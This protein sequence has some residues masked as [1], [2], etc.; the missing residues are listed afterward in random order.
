M[1]EDMFEEKEKSE[2]ARFKLNEELRFKATARR[3]RKLG[4]WVADALGLGPAEADDYAQTLVLAG[5]ELDDGEMAERL[6]AD[7]KDVS[8]KDVEKEME[9]LYAVALEEIAQD[10]PMPL[11]PDHERVGD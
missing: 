11:G 1:T 2:E 7:L 3:N 5:L 8:R 9:R 10:Y 4:L 6:L